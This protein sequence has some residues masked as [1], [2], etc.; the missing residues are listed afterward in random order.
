MVSGGRGG[1]GASYSAIITHK[2]HCSPKNDHTNTNITKKSRKKSHKDIAAVDSLLE[3]SKLADNKIVESFS[4]NKFKKVKL[5]F[6]S[7]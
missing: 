6:V 5:P 2:Y 7:S 3:V 4:T 1:S